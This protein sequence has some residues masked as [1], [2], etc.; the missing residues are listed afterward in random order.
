MINTPQK[1]INFS[2]FNNQKLTK[3]YQQNPKPIKLLRETKAFSF[4]TFLI[5]K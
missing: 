2:K 1:Q 3:T 4:P 5:T